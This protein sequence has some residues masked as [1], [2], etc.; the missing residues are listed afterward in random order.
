MRR[1]WRPRHAKRPPPVTLDRE[2]LE[3]FAD[4]PELLAIA[5]AA[6]TAKPR[7]RPRRQ[8]LIA[9][10]AVLVAVAVAAAIV[11]RPAGGGVIEKAR[12]AVA[13]G[14]V[15]R[16]TVLTVLSGD[17]IVDLRQ[18][19]SAPSRAR[20]DVWFD[21]RSSRLLVLSARNGQQVGVSERPGPEEGTITRF[22]ASYRQALAEESTRVV[23]TARRVLA[24]DSP[25]FVGEVELDDNYLP[26]IVR[27]RGG[28]PR[29]LALFTVDDRRPIA[30]PPERVTGVGVRVAASRSVTPAEA[31]RQSGIAPLAPAGAVDDLPL[32]AVYVQQLLTRVA[33]GS[34]NAP[35]I[36]L[37]YGDTAMRFVR[38]RQARAPAA[39]YGFRGG[40]TIGGNP[41]PLAPRL[42]LR[43]IE[44][45]R[46]SRWVGQFRTGRLFVTIDG[47]SRELV[48]N[49]GR[50]LVR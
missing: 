47:S 16:A 8:L 5:D 43:K 29:S 25:G 19:S 44:E 30:E 36:E 4:E 15:L 10:T 11:S 33:H 49:A 35:G 50:L 38:L 24:I 14:D 39:V 2:V 6:S 32:T 7:A 42:D 26:K 18:G 45:G 27:P 48:I 1:V 31:R 34:L 28:R 41:V 9:A 22:V 40:L 23:S 13:E 37:V 17:E 3:L 46:S 21:K 20:S 12:D